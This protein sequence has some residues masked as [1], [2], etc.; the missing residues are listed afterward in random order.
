MPSTSPMNNSSQN[1]SPGILYIVAT[2]IGNLKDITL[3]ALDVLSTVDII[4]AEDTRKTGR[5]LKGRGIKA[6]F[7]SYHEH[8][9][10]QRC[11]QLLDKLSSGLSVAIVSNAGTPS[12]SDPGFRL[13]Q[14]AVEKKNIQII[15][16]P[17][18]SAVIS[19]LSA[20]GL[21]SDGFV[22]IGFLARKR[23]RRNKQLRTLADLPWTMIFYESPKRL[24][25]LLGDIVNVMGDRS[26]VLAREMT[27]RHEEFVRGRLSELMLELKERPD[28]KGECTLI[29]A[30]RRAAAA[31]DAD[32]LKEELTTRLKQKNMRLS[33]IVREVAQST[34]LPKKRV[35]AEALNIKKMNL[36]E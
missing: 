32:D 20:S 5:F 22:F 6:R 14:R 34:G 8:N 36:Y 26:A 16:I 18:P 31:A 4:A 19:A 29:V 25:G 2:P 7:I 1:A 3:R 10:R 27:K 35:Y 15:P 24:L 12:V 13:V 21:P 30:G 11:Q 33:E 23:G 17:G 9:E 28:I